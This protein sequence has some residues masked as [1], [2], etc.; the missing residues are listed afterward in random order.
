MIYSAVLADIGPHPSMHLSQLQV[1]H[2]TLSRALSVYR[3]TPQMK[4]I[5]HS[6]ACSAQTRLNLGKA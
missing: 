5:H 4:V 1:K 2:A 3:P 6:V